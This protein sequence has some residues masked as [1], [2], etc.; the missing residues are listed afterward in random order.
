MVLFGSPSH[1]K[2]YKKYVPAVVWLI[3]IQQ[4]IATFRRKNL[5]RKV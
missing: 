4:K 2:I 1:M 3:Y 5:H